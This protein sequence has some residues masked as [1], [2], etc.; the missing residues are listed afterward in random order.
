MYET[1]IEALQAYLQGCPLL[2][3]AKLNVDFLPDR[4][5]EYMISPS[6]VDEVLKA[7]VHGASQRQ[8]VF[9]LASKSPIDGDTAQAME[10][11]G[12]FE[13]LI[14]ACPLGLPVFF[15]LAVRCRCTEDAQGQM[16]QKTGL[17]FR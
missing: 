4:P 5:L 14:P 13:R 3:G 2:A 15:C 11:S 12:F 6:P 17:S 9:V 10:N 8:Y 16:I 1:I 7:Y